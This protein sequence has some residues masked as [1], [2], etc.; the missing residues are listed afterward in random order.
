M[1]DLKELYWNRMVPELTVTDFSASLH[2]YIV[3]LGFSI[4]IRRSGPDF[5]YVSFSEAQ[6]M[7][8]QYYEE[9]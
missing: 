7:L 5:A 1:T 3:V 8:E 2:F 6:L 4:I 9:G